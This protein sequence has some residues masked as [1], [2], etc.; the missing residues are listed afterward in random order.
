MK[1]VRRHVA[2]YRDYRKIVRAL[3]LG[4]HDETRV[5]LALRQAQTRNARDVAIGWRQPVVMGAEAATTTRVA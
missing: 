2:A 1:N 4:I 3:E 5:L